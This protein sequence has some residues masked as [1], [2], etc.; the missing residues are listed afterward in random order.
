M[1]IRPTC[2]EVLATLALFWPREAHTTR[3]REL[4]MTLEEAVAWS[5]PVVGKI[6]AFGTV[7]G[8]RQ[9][10]GTKLDYSLATT[11]IEVVRTLVESPSFEAGD[12][13]RL[14]DPALEESEIAG[15]LYRQIGLSK[16]WIEKHYRSRVAS[17]D[18]AVGKTLIFF[19]TDRTFP[20]REAGARIRYLSC[21][22]GYE[23]LDLEK[24]IEKIARA[25]PGGPT[26]VRV[27]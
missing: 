7:K 22:H 24:R 26:R 14:V 9:R 17:E 4:S 23:R 10:N 13:V 3:V 19:V 15:A 1:H 11:E 20:S 21:G 5:T 18:Y 16:H 25:H 27:R 8:E 12:V 6:R 2:L